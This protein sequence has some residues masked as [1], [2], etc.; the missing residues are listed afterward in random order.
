MQYRQ[1]ESPSARGRTSFTP[2]SRRKTGLPGPAL[3]LAR[4]VAA[5][6][7]GLPV[8]TSAPSSASRAFTFGSVM[9][10]LIAVLSFS[11]ISRGV[12]FGA[13]MPRNESAS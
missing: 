3:D 2:P 12:P 6:V 13:E 9:A 4:R 10:A 8:N 5:V 1:I 7:L 11:T